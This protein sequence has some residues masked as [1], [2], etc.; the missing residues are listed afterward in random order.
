MRYEEQVSGIEDP[1]FA[2]GVA[3]QLLAEA[4]AGEG[5]RGPVRCIPA[6]MWAISFISTAGKSIELPDIARDALAL[7]LN[8]AIELGSVKDMEGDPD[9]PF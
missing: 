6:G 2:A 9:A 4:L 3:V 7:L 8:A 1:S 5:V